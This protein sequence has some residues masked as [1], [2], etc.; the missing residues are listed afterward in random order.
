MVQSTSPITLEQRLREIHTMVFIR[1]Y[2]AGYEK[3][4]ADSYA[5]GYVE[6]Y[7]DAMKE[8]IISLKDV[9]PT[10]TLAQRYK[11]RIEDVVQIINKS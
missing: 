1:R 9:V 4:Y 7:L 8:V 2:S 3:P 6:G 10:D 11:I 5:D